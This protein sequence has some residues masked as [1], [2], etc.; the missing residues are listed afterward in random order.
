MEE[1]SSKERLEHG[2]TSM[3]AYGRPALVELSGKTVAIVPVG[4]SWTSRLA[5][6]AVMRVSCRIVVEP[7]HPSLYPLEALDHVSG[8][9]H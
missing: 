1:H 5:F 6:T 8:V 4:C 7:G 2:L 9:E 3:M